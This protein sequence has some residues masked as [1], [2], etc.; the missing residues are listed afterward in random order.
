MIKGTLFHT[1]NTFCQ[2]LVKYNDILYESSGIYGKSFIQKYDLISEKII[3]KYVF[4]PDIFAEGLTI[5]NN[6]LYCLS[7][8]NPILFKFDLDLKLLNSYKLNNIK[9]GWGLTTD[10][11][12]LII[13]DG[14]EKLY[15]VDPIDLSYLP[16]KQIITTQK[17]L[18]ALAY[19][20]NHIYSN[21][22]QKDQ[23]IKICIQTGAIIQRWD[24]SDIFR[25]NPYLSVYSDNKFIID[26]YSYGEYVLN[27][28]TFYKDNQ[29]L[30]TGKNWNRIYIV[31]L[32]D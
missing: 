16:N 28:I 10:N 31:E 8:H 2:G 5:L 20:N 21:I 24:F 11:H 19:Y 25:P 22:W 18:N 9:E 30:L 15:I 14:S 3:T 23:I 12:N 29:F 4:E 13:S 1:P 32:S 6:N 17:K 7:W 27:G 26:D